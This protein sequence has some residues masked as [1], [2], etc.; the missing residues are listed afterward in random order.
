MTIYWQVNQHLWWNCQNKDG[1]EE[2][3]LENTLFIGDEICRGSRECFQLCLV[4]GIDGDLG[5]KEGV[6]Y[7]LK[8]STYLGS[9]Y[10]GEYKGE[11]G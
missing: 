1:L 7:S 8:P 11:W 2:W 6:L 5:G 4:D 9:R 3:R 10:K